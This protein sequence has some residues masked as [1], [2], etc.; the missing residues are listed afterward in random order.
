MSE[1]TEIQSTDD[2]H[3]MQHALALA[4]RAR[5]EDDEIPVGAVVIGA[6]GMLLGD[7]L[8]YTSRCV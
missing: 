1:S 3:W 5:D 8:L 4:A 7:C 6:D 2:I